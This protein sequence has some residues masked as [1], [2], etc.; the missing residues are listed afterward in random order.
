MRKLDGGTS[1]NAADIVKNKNL[2]ET[3]LQDIFEWL[4]FWY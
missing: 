1:L 3:H 4:T 2:K